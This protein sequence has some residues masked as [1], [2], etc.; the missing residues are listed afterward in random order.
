[1]A[2]ANIRERL[3]LHFDLEASLDTRVA[4]SRYEIVIVMPYRKPT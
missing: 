2:L 3:L 4:G 1:M